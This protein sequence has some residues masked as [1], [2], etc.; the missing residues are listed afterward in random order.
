MSHPSFCLAVDYGGRA[1]MLAWCLMRCMP[2]GTV[3]L[4]ESG[5]V[6]GGS[7]V[8]KTMIE[9]LRSV[10]R[11]PNF[12]SERTE[13]GFVATWDSLEADAERRRLAAES[14]VRI[15]AMEKRTAHL[16]DEYEAGCLADELIARA[17]RRA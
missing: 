17:R 4:I 12:V 14:A 15:A 10:R 11:M 1:S 16:F 7:R 9:R 6:A 3:T 5:N 13:N 8:P 2:D